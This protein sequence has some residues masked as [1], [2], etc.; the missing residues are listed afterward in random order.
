M[1]VNPEE[2]T[3]G[4]CVNGK[5]KTD[6]PLV[7]QLTWENNIPAM[8]IRDPNGDIFNWD[9]YPRGQTEAEKIKE[10]VKYSPT[11]QTN[12]LTSEQEG[13]MIIYLFE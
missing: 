7:E 11:A 8:V 5:F 2:Q 3:Q 12:S 4:I 10:E 6:H 1:L 13:I 9:Y